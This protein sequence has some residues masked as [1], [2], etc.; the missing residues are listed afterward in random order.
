MAVA[1]GGTLRGFVGTRS[2]LGS[3]LGAAP[4]ARPTD[5]IVDAAR[6][7]QTAGFGLPVVA[8]AVNAIRTVSEPASRTGARR[9]GLIA[10]AADW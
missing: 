2:G 6:C 8:V 1:A 10:E 9:M 5:S 3:G 4:D 7:V